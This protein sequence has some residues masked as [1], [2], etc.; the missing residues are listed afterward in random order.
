MIW[1]RGYKESR[2]DVDYE[3]A[4]FESTEVLYGNLERIPETELHNSYIQVG[5]SDAINDALAKLGYTDVDIISVSVI[6]GLR[7]RGSYDYHIAVR[8]V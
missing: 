7:D 1:V 6:T 8:D 5:A 4:G 2:I 3:Q